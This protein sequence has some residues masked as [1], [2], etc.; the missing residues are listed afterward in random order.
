MFRSMYI[1][2]LE[3]V[4]LLRNHVDVRS[5]MLNKN[6]ISFED[7][8]NWFNV[9]SIEKNRFL[10]VYES[11]DFICG[12]ANVSPV[13]NGSDIFEWGFYLDPDAPK[14]LRVNFGRDLLDYVFSFEMVSAVYGRVLIDNVKSIR[15][16]RRLGFEDFFSRVESEPQDLNVKKFIIYKDKWLKTRAKEF[17]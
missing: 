4:L 13:S 5:V 12:F 1:S 2:D 7:H 6:I 10:L 17:S 11:C 16:H 14:E 15:F 3:R 8:L 9:R